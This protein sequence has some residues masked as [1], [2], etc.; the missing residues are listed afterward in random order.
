METYCPII[1][2]VFRNESNICWVKVD[3]KYIIPYQEESLFHIP[4]FHT[5]SH[6]LRNGYVP[7]VQALWKIIVNKW[8]PPINCIGD[9]NGNWLSGGKFQLKRSILVCCSMFLSVLVFPVFNKEQQWSTCMKMGYSLQEWNEKTRSGE[10]YFYF[11]LSV[12]GKLCLYYV[13]CFILKSVFLCMSKMSY[14]ERGCI[15]G[16]ERN[17]VC[18]FS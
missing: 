17:L 11:K 18:R 1:C 6:W 13:V 3:F 9:I 8:W 2:H 12:V 14:R 16:K 7:I 15:Y 10:W 4:K 5:N